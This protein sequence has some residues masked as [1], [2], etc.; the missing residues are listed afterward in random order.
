MDILED[1]F[2][3]NLKLLIGACVVGGIGF[4]LLVLLVPFLIFSDSPKGT[5][6]EFLTRIGQEDFIYAHELTAPVFKEVVDEE[7][8]EEM[9]FYWGLEDYK[10]IKWNL[11]DVKRGTGLLKGIATTQKGKKISLSMFF[12]K[13]GKEWQLAGLSGMANPAPQE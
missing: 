5:A 8:L 12:I 10:S 13:S 7:K 3:G 4:M 1:K 11:K 6:E 2:K 9:C